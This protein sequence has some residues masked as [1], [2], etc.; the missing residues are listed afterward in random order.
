MKYSIIEKVILS[1][2]P[3]EKVFNTG[4]KSKKK[5]NH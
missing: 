4:E 2:Q 5:K 3:S 1:V